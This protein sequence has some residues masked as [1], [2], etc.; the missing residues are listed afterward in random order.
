M[1]MMIDNHI[2]MMMMMLIMVMMMMM[3]NFNNTDDVYNDFKDKLI[4]NKSKSFYDVNFIQTEGIC[5]TV[6]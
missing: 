6:K 3:V 5:Y 1:M 2:M 4:Y